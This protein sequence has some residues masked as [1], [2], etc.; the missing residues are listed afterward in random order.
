MMG[1]GYLL[2]SDAD[3]VGLARA[4]VTIEPMPAWQDRSGRAPEDL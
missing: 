3:R 1:S 4:D 2:I